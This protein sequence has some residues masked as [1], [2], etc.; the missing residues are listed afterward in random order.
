MKNKHCPWTRKKKNALNQSQLGISFFPPVALFFFFFWRHANQIYRVPANQF[1]PSA[2]TTLFW[3][4]QKSLKIDL[5]L[6]SNPST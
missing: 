4:A 2:G 6:P 3:E 5:I 1:S